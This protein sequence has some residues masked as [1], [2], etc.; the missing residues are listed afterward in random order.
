MET[1]YQ[2]YRIIGRKG[3]DC[4]EAVA[5]MN[6]EPVYASASGLSEGQEKAIEKLKAKINQPSIAK[7]LGCSVE[8]LKA[9]HAKNA[10][11]LKEMLAKAIKTG[12]KVNGYT[13]SQL[14]TMVCD[15]LSLS[16]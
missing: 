5:F 15:T 6:N 10:I 14:R 8:Q 11:G 9:Q 13:E 7:M 1:T 16:I 3:N 2:G 4:F 12:K